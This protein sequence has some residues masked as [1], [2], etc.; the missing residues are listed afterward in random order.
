MKCI[1]VDNTIVVLER[2]KDIELLS[3][4]SGAKSNPFWFALDIEHFGGERSRIDLGENEIQA[5][6]TMNQIYEILKR[7]G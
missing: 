6:N 5:H 3:G 2:V 7:E 1:K 4:G